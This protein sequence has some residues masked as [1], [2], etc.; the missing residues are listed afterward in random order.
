[1]GAFLHGLAGDLA[2]ADLSQEGMKAGDL[3]RYLPLAWRQI[4]H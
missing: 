4:S 2:A 3:I 1:M